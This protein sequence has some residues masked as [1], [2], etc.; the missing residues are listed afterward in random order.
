MATATVTTPSPVV[1]G[2]V[3]ADPVSPRHSRTDSVSSTSSAGSN[4]T[5][6]GPVPPVSVPVL[7][8]PSP[9]LSPKSS[10][11]AETQNRLL[12]RLSQRRPTKNAK[13]TRGQGRPYTEQMHF[14][15]VM[16]NSVE[17]IVAY[18][19][20]LCDTAVRHEID[21]VRTSDFPSACQTTF[22]GRPTRA[23]AGMTALPGR[24][25]AAAVQQTNGG[26][27]VDN[28]HIAEGLRSIFGVDSFFACQVIRLST[29]QPRDEPQPGAVPAWHQAIEKWWFPQAQHVQI[30]KIIGVPMVPDSEFTCRYV[31]ETIC[32]PRY[33]D[34]NKLFLVRGRLDHQLWQYTNAGILE[35]ERLQIDAGAAEA[36]SPGTEIRAPSPA[37]VD[38]IMGRHR[39][40]KQQRS[41]TYALHVPLHVDPGA[42]PRTTPV[43]P[44]SMAYASPASSPDTSE[45][46]GQ[47]T[48][49][50]ST[51]S[52]SST[53]TTQAPIQASVRSPRKHTIASLC[54]PVPNLPIYDDGPTRR[55]SGEPPSKRPRTGPVPRPQSPPPRPPPPPPLRPVG[56][57]SS[58]NQFPVLP[59]IEVP[60]HPQPPRKQETNPL[61]LLA[62]AATNNAPAPDKPRLVSPSPVSRH[63]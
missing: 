16:V 63:V 34:T 5:C 36:P 52:V 7:A 47:A 6:S 23:S 19:L 28:R 25:P 39:R 44:P 33:K 42:R 27:V 48:R 13:R 37:L 46:D 50:S 22:S 21:F 24:E 45:T 40:S 29:N 11:R 35:Q 51:P 56:S 55:H 57:A 1:S 32:F 10:D 26:Y 15:V 59:R 9:P 8:P 4:G 12:I 3:L 58:C 30:Q 61:L 31:K 17:D 20:G 18:D 38:L 14:D 43:V 62:Y 2:A 49:L 41:F 54:D 60:G 53:T